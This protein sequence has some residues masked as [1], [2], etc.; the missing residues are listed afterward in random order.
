MSSRLGRGSDGS[1][2][3]TVVSF[4][5]RAGQ[6]SM[7]DLLWRDRCHLPQRMLLVVSERVD[8]GAYCLGYT[9]VAHKGAELGNCQFALRLVV[10][11]LV[12]TLATG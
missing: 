8:F 7:K 11:V 9:A 5:P 1:K 2:G 6:Q 12:M 3:F 10:V 4:A